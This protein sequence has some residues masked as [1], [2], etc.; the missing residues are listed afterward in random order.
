MGSSGSMTASTAIELVPG[1][2]M[3]LNADDNSADRHNVY[4]DLMEI[5]VDGTVSGDMVNI[6]YVNEA[7]MKY[8]S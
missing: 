6:G 2:S 8:N 7:Y 5:F 3:Q 4:L 1:G